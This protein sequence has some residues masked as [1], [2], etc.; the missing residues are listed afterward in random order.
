MADRPPADLKP[1]GRG[2]ALWRAVTREY[3][4][5]P[6]EAVVLHEAGRCLD[7]IDELQAVIDRDGPLGVGSRKQSRVNPAVSE[8]RQQQAQLTRLLGQ[9]GAEKS[10]PNETAGVYSLA[11][12]RGTHAVNARWRRQ[13]DA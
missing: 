13:N 7:R 6:G 9:L 12:V 11:S 5:T 8:L 2:R 3:E 4:L 10:E 1:G